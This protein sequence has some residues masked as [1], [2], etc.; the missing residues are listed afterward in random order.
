MG[1]AARQKH[2]VTSSQALDALANRE[3]QFQ[4]A[5]LDDV[6]SSGT[7]KTNREASGWRVRDDAIAV[8]SNVCE[9]LREQIA[10]P[11]T[12]DEAEPVAC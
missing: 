5:V 2:G 6:Q 11:S 3:H 8:Q 1:V 9:Q 7:L 12:R 4:L 10:L